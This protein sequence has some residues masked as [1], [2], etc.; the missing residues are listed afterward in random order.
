M[1]EVRSSLRLAVLLALAV[2][3]LFEVLAMLQGFRSSRRLQARVTED[4]Q[5][6]VESAR[7]RLLLRAWAGGTFGAGFD[8][9]AAAALGPGV[10]SEVEVI[11]EEGR[12]VFS[13]PGPPPVT[14]VLLPRERER[15]RGGRSLT[16]LAQSGPRMRAL[17]YVGLP[18][19]GRA[20]VLRLATLVPDLE[21]DLNERRQVLLGQG[22]ALGALLL[23]AALL[24]LP[25]RREHPVS[26]PAA[27][28]AYE[29]AMERL[30]DRGEEMS[31]RHEAQKRLMED[32]LREKEAMARAGELT[33][34]IVHEVRNGLGTIVGHAR[35]LER[36]GGGGAS[37]EAG[38][39][40][41]EEC[42][43]L[44][45]VVRRFNDF[46][47]WERL[48]LAELD[49]ASLLSKVAARELRGHEGVAHDL[50]SLAE[51]LR[52]RGDQHLL[53]RAFEN[54]V[55]NAAEAAE[56]GGRHVEISA[57]ISGSQA[58][59]RIADDGPGLPPGHTGQARPFFTTKPGGLGLGL[60]IA[61][62]VVLLHGGLLRLE[63]REPRGVTAVVTMP[64]AGPP[65]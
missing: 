28:E 31:A 36:G 29:E 46:I 41:R 38:R 48:D 55:R 63:N 62:K 3:A 35:L 52:V 18:G 49:L 20:L 58:L 64:V 11:D 17:T 8:E 59:V 2:V 1:A 54:L 4:V 57:G 61:R 14:H 47:R 9:I 37:A 32:S 15:I 42:E 40:I 22:A 25:G 21:E 7:P 44:E 43:T 65:G 10:A 34:G 23:A 39:A 51:P 50:S 30:R 33:A 26:P 27:L 16:V 45:T 19:A 12:V 53:E 6:Q 56:E 24:L 5:R 60:S 13:R